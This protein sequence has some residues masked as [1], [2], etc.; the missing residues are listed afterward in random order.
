MEGV[1]MTINDNNMAQKAAQM[2]AESSARLSKYQTRL[3]AGSNLL[4]LQGDVVDL[5]LHRGNIEVSSNPIHDEAKAKESAS[6]A[7]A[8]ILNHPMLALL[9]QANVGHGAVWNLMKF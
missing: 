5:T 2:L 3:S 1:K 9:G 8:S 7:K 6:Y 4:P